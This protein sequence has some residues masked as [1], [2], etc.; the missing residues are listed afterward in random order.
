MENRLLTQFNTVITSQ[1]LSQKIVEKHPP[2]NNRELFELAYHACNSL[3]AR[4]IL[5]K[6]GQDDNKG[7][8]LAVLYSTNKKFFS[9]DSLDDTLKIT[10]YFQEGDGNKLTNE[11]YPQL[12]KWKEKYNAKSK[13]IKEQ[14]LKTVLVERKLDECANLVMLKE[15]NRKIY[16]A[17]GDSRESAA[18]VPMFM[19]AEGASLVQLA[20][21]RWMATAQGLVQ[22]ENFPENLVNG[23]LKNLM[24]IK[25]WVLN[26]ITTNLDK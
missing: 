8:S 18:V 14:I 7:G 3:D 4:A 5:I 13:E 26:L 2:L 10:M 11:I 6:L 25:K 17:I 1:W 22:E 9:V 23:I 20:L 24:Q 15:K 19:E 16:F 12:K 21:N